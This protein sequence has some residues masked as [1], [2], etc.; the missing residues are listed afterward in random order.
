M[1]T[2]RFNPLTAVDFTILNTTRSSVESNGATS[3]DFDTSDGTDIDIE[4]TGFAYDPDGDDLTGGTITRIDI[5]IGGDQ[6]AINGGDINI[7]DLD[8][9]NAQDLN[10][11]DNGRFSLFGIALQGN[12]TFLM[13]GLAEDG[14]TPTATNRIFGDD[15]QNVRSFLPI[16]TN[17][18]AG[19]DD[20]FS[21]A[22]NRFEVSCDVW[23]LDTSTGGLML[24]STYIGGDDTYFGTVTEEF[25]RVAGDAWTI[26]RGDGQMTLN[27]GDDEIDLGGNSS[28]SSFIA[29]DV[30]EMNNGIVN[31]GDD[32]LTS[33][34]SATPEVAGD[35]RNYNGGTLN[36]G[37]D[38]ITGANST[39]MGGDVMF[40]NA[41]VP[42]GVFTITGGDDEITGGGGDDI[43][44]GDV[45]DRNSIV[46]NLIVGGDDVIHGGAGDDDIFGEVVF[47]DGVTGVSGGNDVLFGGA[48]NDEV[49]GQTGDDFIDGGSGNDTLDGGV[50]YDV[51]SYGTARAGIAINLL[52]VGSQNTIGAGLDS[53]LGFEGLEGSRYDDTLRGNNVS[54]EIDGGRGDDIVFSGAGSDVLFGGVGDDTLNTVSQAD[55]LAVGGAGA[56]LFETSGGGSMLVGGEGLDAVSFALVAAASTIDLAA[57]TA[58]QNAVATSDAL[59]G[60]ENAIGGGGGDSILGSNGANALEGGGGNDTIEGGGEADTISGGDQ[61]DVLS[62]GNASD[63]LS[64]DSGRDTLNGEAGN[65]VLS[66]GAGADLLRGGDSDDTLTGGEG[67]DD[68]RGD[69]GVDSLRGGE[70]DDTLDGGTGNDILAGGEG[71]DA[72]TGRGGADTMVFDPTAGNVTDIIT[73]FGDT[74]GIGDD[75]IDVSAYAFASV[76]SITASAS[77]N[78][79]VL[80]FGGGDRVRLV[81]YLT[82][83][84]LSDIGADDFIL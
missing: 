82:D 44:G 46:D 40:L 56:D 26:D 54:N 27:A 47:G 9:T 37:D 31:G 10:T 23:S 71:A 16:G 18:N 24:A 21:S 66:G 78:D 39:R 75:L 25:H 29:G 52:V 67:D 51:L 72:Y 4:G 12:D 2:V 64:G 59:F 57:G 80:N 73:D 50:G 8:I 53:I 43:I 63:E 13:S 17:T 45:Y 5:D 14:D 61:H 83:H 7:S 22:D 58:K 70:G 20:V 15:L 11:I 65:D 38:V 60:I 76:A 36:A 69:D 68:L 1:A 48:G 3:Y 28:G 55:D 35:V 30:V 62:G 84:A 77:G 42:V 79:V 81:G 34:D 74:G 19:G 49:R 32:E 6:G 33:D 41:P